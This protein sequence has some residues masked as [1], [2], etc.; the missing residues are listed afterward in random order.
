MLL[1][2]VGEDWYSFTTRALRAFEGSLKKAV[3]QLKLHLTAQQQ[4][5]AGFLCSDP[6]KDMYT[7]HPKTLV[8]NSFVYVC[9]DCYLFVC[10]PLSE[11]DMQSTATMLETLYKRINV[12]QK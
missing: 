10:F 2:V 6:L 7:P 11:S 12:E 5:A 4:T 9:V 8:I 1:V 3:N